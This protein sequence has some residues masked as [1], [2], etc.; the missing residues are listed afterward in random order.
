MSAHAGNT[1]ASDRSTVA[2]APHIAAGTVLNPGDWLNIMLSWSVFT[3]CAYARRPS[4]A[5]ESIEVVALA[6]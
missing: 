3:A 4:T 1:V 5:P 2:I 6:K